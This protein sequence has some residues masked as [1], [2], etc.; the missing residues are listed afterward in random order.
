M[1]LDK[2]TCFISKARM[3]YYQNEQSDNKKKLPKVKGKSLMWLLE[4]MHRSLIEGIKHKIG[5]VAQNF[6]Q[7]PMKIKNVENK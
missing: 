2:S 7:K 3:G 5:K 1:F 6:L 4:Y